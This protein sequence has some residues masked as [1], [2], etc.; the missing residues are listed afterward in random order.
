MDISVTGA[1]LGRG[2]SNQCVLP[3]NERIVSSCH[4]SIAHELGQ[5]VITDHSTNGTFLNDSPTPI[6][7]NNTAALKDGDC[8]AMGKYLLTVSLK[9]GGASQ[10]QSEP[11]T[12]ASADS[13]L[14]DLG[15]APASAPLSAPE[16]AADGGL[17]DLDKWLE[18]AAPAPR[19][20]PLWGA[21]NVVQATPDFEEENDPLAAIDQARKADSPMGGSFLDAAPE[22]D[23][24]DWWKGSQKDDVD[25]LSQAFEMPKPAATP[26]FLAE[27]TPV[28]PSVLDAIPAQSPE[29]DAVIPAVD[30]ADDLDALLGLDSTPA[31]A[32]MTD[33]SLERAVTA[34]DMSSA[35]VAEFTEPPPQAAPA[36]SV[37]EPEPEPEPLVEPVA[38][39]P[40]AFVPQAQ[41]EL[42]PEPKP[43][44]A[45]PA[46]AGAPGDVA[47]T[48]SQLLELG[49]LDQAQ[50]DALAPEVV[51][52]LNV[53]IGHLLELLRAR[54]SIKNELRLDRTMIQ[55]VENNPLKF[56]L[57]EKDAMRY[58]FGEHSGAYMSGSRAV[59]EAFNDIAG[60]Q[61]ALLAGMRSAYEKMLD[62][63]SPDALEHR[64]A[65]A[66]SKGLLGSK[67]ARL[68]DAYVE[69]FDKLQQDP[70][71]SFNRLFGEEFASAY[72]TQV[73]D[74]K[75]STSDR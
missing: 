31:D 69:Y 8:I 6:G 32:D 19:S 55:P 51:A 7:P 33:S 39:Q 5:F 57:T 25:P 42:K 63:F 10:P 17:D 38:Q 28:P 70:E 72:E 29:V 37:S 46:T 26:E 30:D 65:E 56:A 50:L 24:P 67:K 18:P 11:Q 16:A 49:N 71:T 58:L 12:P 48:L 36:A 3:D 52:V 40:A 43:Q 53:T 47:Q 59:K 61:M 44:P 73:D 68:W 64:F 13:F 35:F 41:P 22:S 23:D 20:Q 14:D 15:V 2:P 34:G 66:A 75:S 54:S 60:H 45:A 1:A 4:A 74:I 27:P 62:K 9:S 21:S